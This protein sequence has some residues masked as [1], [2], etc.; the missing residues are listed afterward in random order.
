M[1]SKTLKLTNRMLNGLLICPSFTSCERFGKEKYGAPHADHVL[2]GVTVT[3][4]N[5]PVKGIA[6]KVL[7]ENQATVTGSKDD[8][9]L[10][11]QGIRHPSTMTV[12][13]RD[14]GGEK[15]ARFCPTPSLLTLLTQNRPE[16]A[17]ARIRAN[18]QRTPLL[19]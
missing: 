5:T 2:K 9:V 18:L 10:T 19:R 1:K 8:F 14:V 12:T 4:D 3:T 13:V 16:T 15:T 11:S 7:Y 6:L 17:T